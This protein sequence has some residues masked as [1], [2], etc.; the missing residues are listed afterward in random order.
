MKSLEDAVIIRLKTHGENYEIYVDPDAALKYKSGEEIGLDEILIVES[1]YKDAK[2]GEKASVEHLLD[3]FKVKDIGEVFQKILR[4]G[5]LHLTTEQKR[6]MHEERR[7][8]IVS[9]IVRNAINPQTKTPHPLARIE[10]AM[11]EARVEIVIS[12]SAKEQVDKIVKALK[13]IIPIKFEKI[14]VAVQVPP[15][16]SGRLYHIIHEFGEV[17]KEDWISGEQYILIEMPAGLQDDFYSKI[18][19]ATHG[20]VKTKV[21]KHE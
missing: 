9:I 4:D 21:V 12:K 5:E 16:Y 1:I 19:G 8:Q 14:E 17:K 10:S 3:L 6:A 2:T 20:A 13:P 15:E 18:N 7:K 11:E